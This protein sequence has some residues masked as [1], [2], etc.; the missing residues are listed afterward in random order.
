M[1]IFQKKLETKSFQLK[2]RISCFS[3]VLALVDKTAEDPEW[4]N[5][6][7]NELEQY[8]RIRYFAGCAHEAICD[9]FDAEKRFQSCSWF[10]SLHNQEARQ[11][12]LKQKAYYERRMQVCHE[13][14]D[15]LKV[16]LIGYI[17]DSVDDIPG[18]PSLYKRVLNLMPQGVLHDY[19]SGLLYY[20]Q[21]QDT[22]ERSLY[23]K[24]KA[25]VL[26]VYH[27]SCD[28]Y[29]ER[30]DL[31]YCRARY[32]VELRRCFYPRKVS[33]EKNKE[34]KVKE[35]M[36]LERKNTEVARNILTI[37]KDQNYLPAMSYLSLVNMASSSL[38]SSNDSAVP[39]DWFSLLEAARKNYAP[40]MVAVAEMLYR[41]WGGELRVLEL[42]RRGS[43]NGEQE[44]FPEEFKAQAFQKEVFN[45]LLEAHFRYGNQHAKYLVDQMEGMVRDIPLARE[46]G[47][48]ISLSTESL[49]TV[50]TTCRN[51][52]L[53]WKKDT[54]DMFDEVSL[55]GSSPKVAE[56]ASR[57]W[58]R[59][60][61]FGRRLCDLLFPQHNKVQPQ[62]R[63]SLS[64]GT[65]PINRASIEVSRKSV[66]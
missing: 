42:K 46:K 49:S 16:H 26:K 45:M 20:K 59:R 44:G 27:H 34:N 12:Y 4:I 23:N 57:P 52:A 51:D 30:Q 39:T 7:L 8:Q 15:M 5:D 28:T 24:A 48:P 33:D 65:M 19:Y 38:E 14:L 41:Y 55:S 37:L 35:A 9:V 50:Y 36:A 61:S 25:L 11:K 13:A 40:A 60:I 62:R 66:A 1:S 17:E 63:R 58:R 31:L 43:Y 3:A 56:P 10:Q 47:V 32:L 54:V 22:G 6:N 18:N 64:F 2:K 53:N 29:R 21:H